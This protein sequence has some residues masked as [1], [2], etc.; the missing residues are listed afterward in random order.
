MAMGLSYNFTL[1]GQHRYLNAGLFQDKKMA[2]TFSRNRV[3]KIILLWLPA[4]LYM[5]LIFYFSSL[6]K[7]IPYELP[8]N[9]YN[10]IHI[11]EYAVLG[12]LMSYSLKNSGADKY[13]LIAWI[14]SSCYG[15]T[16]EIHQLFVF[17]RDASI[18]DVSADTIGSL[19]GA[20]CYRILISRRYC[21]QKTV[22]VDGDK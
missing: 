16:D 15:I 8:E 5:A 21:D 19:A 13:F 11:I 17:M 12:F 7:P 9:T 10:A 22:N 14:S 1:Y 18:V 20:Y 6:S 2:M 4:I 3:L